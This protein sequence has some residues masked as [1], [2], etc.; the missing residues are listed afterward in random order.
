MSAS[1]IPIRLGHESLDVTLAYLKG[2]DAES[3]SAGTCQQQQPGAIRIKA[4]NITAGDWWP[5]HLTA[6]RHDHYDPL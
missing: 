1:T 3:R 6:F 4:T 5:A 2:K